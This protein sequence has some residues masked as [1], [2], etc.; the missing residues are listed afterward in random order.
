VQK[1]IGLF[2]ERNFYFVN[3]FSISLFSLFS[4]EKANIWKRRKPVWKREK[5]NISLKMK[6]STDDL[7]EN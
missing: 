2:N 5:K 6:I 4:S 1:K 7:S 3:S